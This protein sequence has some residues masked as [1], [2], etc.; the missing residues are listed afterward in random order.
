MR[1]SSWIA[2]RIQYWAKAPLFLEFSTTALKHGAMK[3]LTPVQSLL[4]RFH[5]PEL[6][7]LNS[8]NHRAEARCHEAI[9][10]GSIVVKKISLPCASPE[11]S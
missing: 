10:T 7:P 11:E 1:F 2:D 3:P 5:C 4:K 9:D 8:A 6:W